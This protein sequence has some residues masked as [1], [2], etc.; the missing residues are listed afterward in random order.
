MAIGQ[1]TI[2]AADWLAAR[3]TDRLAITVAASR[4]DEAAQLGGNVAVTP[5]EEDGQ[6]QLDQ[7]R[8]QRSILAAQESYRRVAARIKSRLANRTETEPAG[9][10]ESAG[11]AN[12]R[13]K[14]LEG[15]RDN[16]KLAATLIAGDASEAKADKPATPADTAFMSPDTDQ[17]QRL[18]AATGQDS[19]D[20]DNA[21]TEKADPLSTWE[22]AE[23]RADAIAADAVFRKGLWADLFENADAPT[24]H[25]PVVED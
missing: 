8:Q 25:V 9:S 14:L 17:E 23:A 11:D 24:D 2:S 18:E 16:P 5:S 19:E 4:M 7:R 13:A 22:A 21:G 12:G 15:L 1:I 3:V 20:A 6:S 10:S